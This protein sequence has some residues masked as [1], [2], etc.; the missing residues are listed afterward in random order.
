M[1]H[2]FVALLIATLLLNST[3]SA[4]ET[5]FLPA[6]APRHMTLPDGFRATLFAGEPDLVQPIA[7]CTDARGRLW[8]IE[9]L[10]YPKWDKEG[11]DRIVIF[12][13]IDGDGKFDSR[14]VFFDKG[15]NF[16]GI[17]VGFGGVWVCATPNFVFIP[18]KD[19]NDQADGPP[20]VL[21]DGWDLNARHNVFAA[22]RWGPDGWLYGCNGILSNSKLGKPGTPEDERIPLNCGVWRYHPLR[23]TFEAFAWG[24]TNP[25]GLDFD[26]FGEMFITNCVIKHLWHVVPGAHF[27]RMFGQDLNPYTF[28]LLSSAADHIHWGGGSWY[29]SRGGKGSHDKPGGGH[30][31]S[32][33]MLY[34]GDNWPA[35]Y[36]NN[37][38]TCNIHGSRVNRDELE[39]NGSTYVAHHGQDFL[40]ANDPWF[41]GLALHY[42]PDGGVFV[43][44]WCDTGECHDY[45]EVHRTSGRIYKVTFGQT[46]SFQGD[47]SRAPDEQLVRLQLHKNDWHVRH[48]RRVLQERAAQGKLSGDTRPA[49]QKM[50]FEHADVTRRLRALWALHVTGGVDEAL[51]NRLIADGDENLR[52]WGV[53]LELE[54]KQASDKRL[55]QFTAMAVDE[56]SPRVRLALASALQRLPLAQRWPVAEALARHAEDAQDP[57]LPLMVWYGVEPLVPAQPD[58]AVALAVQSRIPLVRELISRRLGLMPNTATLEPLVAALGTSS[59]VAF[60]ADLLRGLFEA[61]NGRRNVAMP[62][63]WKKVSPKLH[64]STQAEVREKSLI[65]SLIFG[66]GEAVTALRKTAADPQATLG[67]RRLALQ[68]LSQHRDAE[69]LPVLRQ[70][71]ADEQ[72]RG[73]ALLALTAYNDPGTPEAILKQYNSFNV[74]DKRDAIST[75]VSRPAYAIAL[76]EAIEKERV[77]RSDLSAFVVRQLRNQKDEKLIAKLN[78]VWGAARETP[79]D[80]AALILKFKTLLAPTELKQADR[81][82]GRLV[83]AKTCASCHKLFDAGT[84]IGPELTGGQRQNLDYVLE[85]LIDP[86]ALVSRDYQVTTV[87]LSDGRVLNGLVRAE[88]ENTLTLLMPNGTVVLPK[89]DIEDR[90]RQVVSL[91]PEGMLQKFTEQELRDLVAYLASP[92]QVPLPDETGK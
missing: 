92:E 31:H 35:E 65:L 60:Q 77:P 44:D 72:L 38:F 74:D 20:Q 42:G 69:L 18:D 67:D 78:Q 36:R 45:E 32:G 82:R 28:G 58:R 2:S 56:K 88:N 12:D 41:R 89:S 47:L 48:A 23:H 50:L 62:K 37:V 63:E 6:E 27:E 16:S 49:L 39:R 14:K 33:A 64:S 11:Q 80:K 8:V 7:F 73:P 70:L 87:Q 46:A 52:S 53:R 51:T 81:S 83:Y 10:S 25:W 85:N 17:E 40:M 61:L 13:D 59:D 22:L 4:Q 3:L 54:D 68:A 24:T 29:E 76:L 91:M 57:Y 9:C 79:Q 84:P 90:N 71:L 19:G 66:N 30:A 43:S 5:P 15:A 21:L 75:L 55:A 26:D 86:N 1:R 34:L